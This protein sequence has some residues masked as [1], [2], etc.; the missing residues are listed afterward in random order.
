MPTYLPPID[1]ENGYLSRVYE[2]FRQ[3]WFP[4]AA[5]L[6]RYHVRLKQRL[7]KSWCQPY[8]L[9][10]MQGVLSGHW[11]LGT[12]QADVARWLDIDHSS[13][14]RAVRDGMASTEFLIPLL[15][16]PTRPSNWDPT[17]Q[18][19]LQQEMDRY[20]FIFSVP[21]AYEGGSLHLSE[22]DYELLF[23][24][25]S[26]LEDWECVARPNERKDLSKQIVARVVDRDAN[27]LLRP[28]YNR[29][30]RV[31]LNSRLNALYDEPDLAVDHLTKLRDTWEPAVVFTWW[32]IDEIGW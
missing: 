10:L 31:E 22:L 2:E 7:R 8:V 30:E 9:A 14:S 4:S 21:V 28:W 20:A 19:N 16:C 24:F 26:R 15:C 27:Y 23:S 6:D 29:E 5:S 1:K 18:L 11:S 32:S 25:W 13:V 12:Q 3:Q 17:L